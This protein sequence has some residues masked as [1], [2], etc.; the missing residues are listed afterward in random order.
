MFYNCT[1][2]HYYQAAG[3]KLSMIKIL[4]FFVSDHIKV[5][6]SQIQKFQWSGAKKLGFDFFFQFSPTKFRRR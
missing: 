3:E 6:D 5:D 1:K 4:K 2:S